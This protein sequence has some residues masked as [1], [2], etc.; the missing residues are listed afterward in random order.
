MSDFY[1]KEIWRY[2]VKS[3]QGEKLTQCVLTKGGIPLDRGWAVRDE[4]TKAIRGA[5]H[6]GTLLNCKARYLD[7]TSAGIV[8]HVEIMLPD[9]T[10]TRSDAIDV[11]AKLSKALGVEVTLWPLQPAENAEH[12]KQVSETGDPIA[13]L[14]Q[15]FG[16]LPNEPM[17][18]L[19]T[20]SPEVI[21]ELMTYTSPR[22]TYFDAYPVNVLTE[23]SLRYFQTLTPTSVLDVRRF[24][25]NFLLGDT[26]QEVRMAEYDWIGKRVRLGTA[27]ISVG[28][29][30]PRCIMTTREQ[31]ELPRD[32]N[33]M[34]TMVRETG[35]C[36]SIYADVAQAGTVSMNDKVMT[37]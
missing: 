20:F 36:L 5:K 35:Q 7:G 13:D 23:A 24:R 33:I 37:V 6:F 34:R 17:A 25:P 10:L 8:P 19:S 30:A 26:R 18:D 32:A 27:Q 16:L 28:L 1:V 21:T 9:G 29:A 22:G 14:R 3:M 12:Y 4:K 2:P 11:H 15:I 31:M